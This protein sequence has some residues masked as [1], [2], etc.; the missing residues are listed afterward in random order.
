[1]GTS[2][3]CKKK[4]FLAAYARCGN[5]TAAA[6]AAKCHRNSHYM[7]MEE[8]EDENE[9]EH[10]PTLFEEASDT[11]VER[12]EAEADRRALEGY[13][14]PVF[15]EGEQCG[16]KRRYSDVLLIFRLKALRPEKYR[17]RSEVRTDGTMTLRIAETIIPARLPAESGNGHKA[18]GN[19]AAPPASRLPG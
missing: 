9:G 12:M 8:K 4:A 16:T 5:I 18:N 13:D 1:M 14:E 11:A 10:Y 15:Y 7:W 17:D 3:R 6:K 19:G 2:V